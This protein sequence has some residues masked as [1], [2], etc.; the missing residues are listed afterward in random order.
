MKMILTDKDYIFVK[1]M[2]VRKKSKTNLIVD[3]KAGL[4]SNVLTYLVVDCNGDEKYRDKIV[5]IMRSEV[6][7][8]ETM[9]SVKHHLVKKAMVIFTV[10]IEDDEETVDPYSQEDYNKQVINSTI[11]T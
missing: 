1:P 2:V 7:A 10:N 6:W 11:I 5:G 3:A 9:D 8:Y 4:R